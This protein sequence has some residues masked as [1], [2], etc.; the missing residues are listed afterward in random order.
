MKPI[1]HPTPSIPASDG[2]TTSRPFRFTAVR[3]GGSNGDPVLRGM[4]G[5]RLNLLT[6]DGAMHGA[7]PSRMDNAMSY[8]APDTYDRLVVT[9]GPQTV[10]WGPGASAGTVRFERDREH[11]SDP[12]LKV[13]ASTLGGSFGRNDQVLD[14]LYGASPGYARLTANR[15][16][17]GDYE[18]G[19][20]RTVGSA[21]KKWNTDVAFGWT[22]D[23]DTLL[24]LGVG[25]GDGQARYA[26]RG[27]DGASFR[28]SNY[29]LRFEKDNPGE[30]WR[31]WRRPRTTTSPTT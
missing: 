30:R 11:F 6:N 15:S 18:D 24:E 17:S 14:A 25:T 27:M 2:P 31:G 16:E 22:P 10:L 9:K 3:N 1:R 21:W 8:I 4:F 12:A 7:C 19:S 28:R 5:S 26:T 13:S 20:G 23:E 29:N